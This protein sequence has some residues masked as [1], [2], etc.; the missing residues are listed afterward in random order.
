MST[1]LRN[2]PGTRIKQ[3]RFYGGDDR[4]VCLQLTKQARQPNYDFN[5]GRL[6]D[7][8]QITRLEA[9]K[10]ANELMLFAAELEVEDE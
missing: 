2:V 3:T 5:D 8:I 10:L 4:G 1:D 6:F 9:S 7:Y